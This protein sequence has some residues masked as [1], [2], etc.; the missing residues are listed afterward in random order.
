LEEHITS[1]FGVK[2]KAKKKRNSKLSKPGPEPQIEALLISS[3]L[4]MWSPTKLGVDVMYL[5]G[6]WQQ[7]IPD[8]PCH[9]SIG[10]SEPPPWS[11][12]DLLPSPSQTVRFPLR[13]LFLTGLFL[14]ERLHT[15]I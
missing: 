4:P 13:W 9:S 1:I 14:W 6:C 7:D 5:L 2:E 8:T 15:S 12:L 10:T 11:Q 3:A